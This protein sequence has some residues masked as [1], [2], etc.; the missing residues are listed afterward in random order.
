MLESGLTKQTAL[1]VHRVIHAA[2]NDAIKDKLI[3]ENPAAL[4]DPPKVQV[5]NIVGGFGLFR[6]WRMFRLVIVGGTPARR[7]CG[8]PQRT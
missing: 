2:L 5:R 7:Y 1:H 6:G 8:Q 4:A 3:G